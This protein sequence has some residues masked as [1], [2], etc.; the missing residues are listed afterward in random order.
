MPNPSNDRRRLVRLALTVL[1][2][3]AVVVIVAACGHGGSY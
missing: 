1:V 2:A 3:A